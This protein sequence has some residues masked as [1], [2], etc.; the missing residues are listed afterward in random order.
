M[1]S[2]GIDFYHSCETRGRGNCNTFLAHALKMKLNSFLDQLLH[3]VSRLANRDDA[4]KVGDI[5]S[6]GGWSL[7]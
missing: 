3:F 6:P 1:S 7:S 5:R 4:G 2:G